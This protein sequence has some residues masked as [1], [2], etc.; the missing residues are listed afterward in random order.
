MVGVI[1]AGGR[2]TAANTISSSTSVGGDQNLFGFS[3]PGILKKAAGLIPGVGPIIQ[4]LIPGANPGRMPGGFNPIPLAGAD[5]CKF[6]FS[7][8]TPTSPCT[9]DLVPGPIGG[10]RTPVAA[11]PAGAASVGQFGVGME[12]GIVNRA[13]RVCLKG[14]Q[15]GSDGLC[16]NKGILTNKQREWPRGRRPLLTG[17]EMA[18]IS[19]ASRAAGRLERTTKRLQ[20]I[21]LVKT[22]KS[23]ARA[24]RRIAAAVPAGTSIVNVE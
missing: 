7:R 15:L 23:R 17:G 16:Y 13:I 8:D 14:M 24:P 3:I 21:G 9:L 1:G 6:G 12:P 5:P 2:A 11:G 4:E 19:K 20:K 18:A 22:P 10:R